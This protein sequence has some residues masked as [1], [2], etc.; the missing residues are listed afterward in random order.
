M[1]LATI[2]VLVLLAGVLILL[3]GVV[4]YNAIDNHGWIV[5]HTDLPTYIPG[6]WLNGEVRHCDM[7]DGLLENDGSVSG[8]T[9]G[10]LDYFSPYLD[11][12]EKEAPNGNG[13]L[14]DP[15]HIHKLPVALHGRMKGE[16]PVLYYWRCQRSE[17]GIECWALD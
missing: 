10:D 5:H 17:K 6:E 2:V 8:G 11:C 15:D 1:K 14:G 13:M 3:L 4:G 12:K 9:S 7:V 16:A